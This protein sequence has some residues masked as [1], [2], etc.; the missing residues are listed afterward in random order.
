[1]MG[2]ELDGL[3]EDDEESASQQQAGG[4]PKLKLFMK[5]T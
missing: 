3:V 5:R 2:M 4:A 1:M